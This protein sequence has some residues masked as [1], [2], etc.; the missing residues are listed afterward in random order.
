MVPLSAE[1]NLN[2]FISKLDMEKDPLQKTLA[3]YTPI[4]EFFLKNNFTWCSTNNLGLNTSLRKHRQ[5]EI[6]NLLAQFT[7]IHH[8]SHDLIPVKQKKQSTEN[9]TESTQQI[10]HCHQSK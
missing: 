10:C 9:N 3:D 4:K 5:I 7:E 6:R 8:I 2:A 1:A